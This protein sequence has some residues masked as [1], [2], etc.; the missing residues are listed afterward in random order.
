MLLKY[1]FLGIIVGI[2]PSKKQGN[3]HRKLFYLG[4]EQTTNELFCYFVPFFLT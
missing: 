3:Q 2:G 1:D 4:Q